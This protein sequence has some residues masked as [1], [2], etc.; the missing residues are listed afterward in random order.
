[1]M[2]LVI[3][4]YGNYVIQHVIEHGIPEDRE[5]IVNRLRGDVLKFSQHKF[6]SNV[7][8]KCLIC[9]SVDQKNSLIDE[10]CIE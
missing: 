9:G 6:A 2:K 5:R 3:D 8:E 7:I 10:V 4:Q 1:M